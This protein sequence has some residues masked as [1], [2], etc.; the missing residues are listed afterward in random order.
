MRYRFFLL[1]V[2]LGI[3][4]ACAP[5]GLGPEVDLTTLA[6]PDPLPP[7]PRALPPSLPGPTPGADQWRAWVPPEVTAHGDTIDGHFLLISRTPPPLE[8][9]EPSAPIPRAPKVH[10][11]AKP[12][13]P[14]PLAV[15]APP[16]SPAR[17]L[18][19]GRAS[20]GPLTLPTLGGP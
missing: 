18:S 3:L 7:P 15:P 14:P 6:T 12:K 17:P 1:P 2:A 10:L 5:M 8:T 13:P 11:S 4:T 16:L 20:P 19:G 9:L